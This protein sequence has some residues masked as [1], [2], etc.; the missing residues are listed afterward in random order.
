MIRRALLVL[1]ALVTVELGV[2][3]AVHRD[4]VLLNRDTAVLASDGE[5]PD[6]AREALSRERI[7]RRML[8]RV[9]EVSRRRGETDVHVLALRR[10]VASA[11]DEPRA[12][13]RLA[14]ALRDAGQLDEAERIYRE[15]L[16]MTTGRGPQ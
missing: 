7:S 9:A 10:I 11:P 2:F 5:F 4:V 1:A 12:R 13:L 15:E 6:L 16:G 8:E 3:Y 14:E